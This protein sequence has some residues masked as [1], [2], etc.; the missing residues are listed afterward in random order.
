MKLSLKQ[1]SL[2]SYLASSLLLGGIVLVFT[3]FVAAVAQAVQEQDFMNY[4]NIYRFSCII[5]LVLFGGLSAFLSNR[6][7]I[8]AYSGRRPAPDDSRSVSRK[9]VFL[10]KAVVLFLSAF[11]STLL[12]V[13]APLAVFTATETLVPIVSDAITVK[14][15]ADAFQTLVFSALSAGAVG[16][17][18]AEI[19]FISKSFPTTVI[20][21]LLL[22]CVYGNVAVYAGGRISILLFTLGVSLTAAAAVLLPLSSRAGRLPAE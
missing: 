21:A 2:R 22:S 18:A 12:C 10:A 11:L 15:L 1:S 7:V 8:R 3:Y 13:G 5:G 9:K 20:S 16:L 14:L 17:F 19:G 6:L 4:E